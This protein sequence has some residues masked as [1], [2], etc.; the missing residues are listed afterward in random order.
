[1]HCFPIPMS[2][3]EAPDRNP[4]VSETPPPRLLHPNGKHSPLQN[5][6]GMCLRGPR[7]GGRRRRRG[8][9]NQAR[10]AYND[11]EQHRDLMDELK[12]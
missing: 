10:H 7:G 1:M 11:K 8:A 5:L 2:G 9:N 4:N 12:M 6:D 3:H